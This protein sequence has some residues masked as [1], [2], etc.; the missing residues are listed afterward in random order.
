MRRALPRVS[1]ITNTTH[2]FAMKQLSHPLFLALLS[3]ASASHAHP[4]FIVEDTNTWPAR[5]FFVC[6]DAFSREIGSD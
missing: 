5:A 2:P 3:T 6:L 4:L 1:K